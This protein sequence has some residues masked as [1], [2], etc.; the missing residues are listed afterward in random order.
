MRVAIDARAL[1]GA[2]T[3]I[4]TYTLG[5]ARA[6][7]ARPGLEVGLFAPR[8][9]ADPPAAGGLDVRLGPAIPGLVWTQTA[10]PRRAADWGA[11]VLLAALTI[12][13][14]KSTIPVVSVVHDLTPVTHPEWHAERTLAGFLPFWDRTVE[15]AARFVCVSEATARELTRLYPS[16]RGRVRVAPNG[17]D[18]QFSPAED[19]AA[20]EAARRRFAGGR[21]YILHLG[22]L[23]PRKNVAALVTAC[24]QLWDENASRPDLVLAGGVGWKAAPLLERIE[25]SLHRGRIHLAGYAPRETARDLYRAAEVFV[26]P[27]FAE[28]F[29]LPLAEAMACGAPCV[30]STADALVEVGG[31]AALYAPADD[32]QALARAVA[33]AL[34]DPETR[35]RLSAEGP[36]R[37]GLFTWEAAAAGTAAALEEAAS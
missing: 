9:L 34:E 18:P 24:E 14:V 7:S 15:R 16:T 19:G 31:D 22:T 25:R 32:P 8:P 21:P 26:F 23:E 33:T 28:G 4:G 2:Q 27:S 35:R 1:M 13:P 3:G 37:A 36:R 29:G 10:L 20:R 30:A 11:H 6:L 12:A 17:V 5:I